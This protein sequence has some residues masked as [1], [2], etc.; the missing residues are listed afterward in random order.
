MIGESA[1][2]KWP[3]HVGVKCREAKLTPFGTSFSL[4]FKWAQDGPDP[5]GKPFQRTHYQA[6]P[7][8]LGWPQE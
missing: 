5:L 3:Y 8:A 7:E 4:L 1:E 2:D 6:P